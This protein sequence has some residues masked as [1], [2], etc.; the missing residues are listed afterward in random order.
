MIHTPYATPLFPVPIT[1]RRSFWGTASQLQR[2]GSDVRQLRVYPPGTTDGE[3][4]LLLL[5]DASPAVGAA[6]G[7][8][9]A[10]LVGTDSPVLLGVWVLGTGALTWLALQ[11]LTRKLRRGIRSLAVIAWA[12]GG[13]EPVGGTARMEECAARAD[14]LDSADGCTPAQRERLWA[15]LY[16]LL[17]ERDRAESGH[18]GTQ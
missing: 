5:A 12:E 17:P 4:R 18:R 14:T 11:R 1:T 8:L 2:A 6:V 7:L 3:R 15:E 10:A 9:V 16:F 13:S